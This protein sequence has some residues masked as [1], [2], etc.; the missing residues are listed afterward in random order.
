M[1]IE[2][3]ELQVSQV[4]AASPSLGDR[5]TQETPI[6]FLAWYMGRRMRLPLLC[7]FL[8]GMNRYI[9]PQHWFFEVV[10]PEHWRGL[11]W[12]DTHTLVSGATHAKQRCRGCAQGRV[13]LVSGAVSSSSSSRAIHCSMVVKISGYLDQLFTLMNNITILEWFDHPF[14]SYGPFQVHFKGLKG[15][16]GF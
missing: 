1:V 14:Q 6:W 7:A 5:P 9:H 12:F 15:K 13:A 2:S 3:C 16:G 10:S 8:P 4:R 11:F